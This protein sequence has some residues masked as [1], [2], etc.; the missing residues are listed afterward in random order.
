[1]G[2]VNQRVPQERDEDREEDLSSSIGLLAKIGYTEFMNLDNLAKVIRQNILKASFETKA[3]HIGSALS[4]VEILVALYFKILKKA[5]I[6]LFSKAS[7]ASALYAI[8]AEKGLI[9]RQKVVSY[10]KKYPLAGREV[11]GV[12]WSAGSLGHGLPVALGIALADKKRKVY[13]LVS[14]GELQE[15][16]TWESALFASHHNL[17]NLTVIVDRNYFQACGKTEEILKLEPLAKKWETFGWQTKTIDGHSFQEIEKALKLKHTRPLVIIAKTI[18][19][20]GV[21]WMEK[22]FE[23]HYKNLDKQL[24]EKALLC[25]SE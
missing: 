3:C 7:G 21:S 20:K 12:I 2:V 16:T 18:K 4:C 6:F 22:K 17:N 5:D 15:G 1:M 13:C 8:L 10:L 11:P 24:Y 14:D 9:P 23:W 19:G 25:L